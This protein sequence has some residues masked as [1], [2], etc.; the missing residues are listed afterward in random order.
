MTREPGLL[1]GLVDDGRP[2]TDLGHLAPAWTDAGLI[3]GSLT[4]LWVAVDR[5]VRRRPTCRRAARRR[6]Q[7]SPGS[8]TP[9][10]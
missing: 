2:L 7:R 1:A 8:T 9:L 3:Y 4:L 6:P 5:A 10:A